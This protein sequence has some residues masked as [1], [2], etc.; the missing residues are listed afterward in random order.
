MCNSREKRDF[1]SRFPRPRP[2]AKYTEPYPLKYNVTICDRP[3]VGVAGVVEYESRQADQPCNPLPSRSAQP[4]GR[5]EPTLPALPPR[6]CAALPDQRPYSLSR[7][8]PSPAWVLSARRQQAS[9]STLLTSTDH[10][11]TASPPLGGGFA[12]RAYRPST[13]RRHS[14]TDPPR[15]SQWAS[16]RLSCLARSTRP[17]PSRQPR[18]IAAKGLIGKRSMG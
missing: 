2:C 14:A 8:A 18:A 12:V 7:S 5:P 3:A 13:T 15:C 11:L 9:Q 1:V 10:S 4:S 16:A 6:R 17:K